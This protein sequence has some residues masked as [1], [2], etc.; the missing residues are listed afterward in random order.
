MKWIKMMAVLM[1]VFILLIAMDNLLLSSTIQAD[2]KSGSI[3]D[4]TVFPHDEVIEVYITIDEDTYTNM[5]ENAMSEEIVMAD[6]V[7]NGISFSSVGIRPKGNSSLRFVADT[8]SI[9]YSF[10]VDF[11][12]Y[13]DDQSFF[14]VTK[15]NLNN[16]YGDTTMMSEYMGYEIMSEL[17]A[18][19]SR[20]TYVALHINGEYFGLYLSVEQVNET[21]LKDHYGNAN[22]ELYKPDMGVGSNLKY[23]SDNSEDYTGMFPENLSNYSNKELIELMKVIEEG[24]DLES[25]LD[26]DSFLKYLAMSTVTIHLDNYQ[27]GMFHNYYLYNNN[28]V[29]EWITWDLNSIYNKFPM[30]GLT[31]EEATEFLIDEPVIGEME[32][33]PLINAIFKNDEYVDRYHDYINIL[34]NGYLAEENVENK[35]LSIYEMIKDYVKTDPTAFFTYE[36]FEEALFLDTD[37]NLGLLNFVTKRNDNIAKQLEGTIPSTNNGLGNNGSSE[38]GG[39]PPNGMGGQNGQPQRRDDGKVPPGNN[40]DGEAK[41][42]GDE[43]S[44]DMM[45]GLPKGMNMEDLPEELR[46]YMEN[47]EMPPMD[48]MKELMKDMPAGMMPMGMQQQGMTVNMELLIPNLVV[49]LIGTIGIFGF[50][51][52]LRKQ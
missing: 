35:V 11:N 41:K 49:L 22:N 44:K 45:G 31:D 52:Y 34:I 50:T 10:K 43:G 20:T 46:S 28:G 36:Q 32:N 1:G 3:V 9:R 39:M 2:N 30:A 16:L 40:Q 48:K 47:G 37:T 4:E 23:I 8:D 17:D 27:S 6:I 19:A 24:G 13:I 21:F 51:W 15:L 14:G 38:R 12:Y 29:F 5:N 42:N 26:V 25:V 18:D 33:Y 7:Y